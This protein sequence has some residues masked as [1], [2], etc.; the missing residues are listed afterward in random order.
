[1]AAL[2]HEHDARR[3]V[4]VSDRTHMLRVL[5]I[6]DDLGIEAYGSPTRTSPIDLDDGRRVT[7][8][9]HELGALAAY[10]VTGG[11]PFQDPPAG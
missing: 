9:V 7:A 8:L 6:A 11:G 5:R 4:F 2:L 1:V 10:F 3:A